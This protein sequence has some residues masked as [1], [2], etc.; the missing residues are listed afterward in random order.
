MSGVMA[1]HARGMVHRDLSPRNLLLRSD[2]RLVVA[3]FGTVRHLD[4]ATMTANENFGSLLYIS[5]QQFEDAHSAQPSDDL[6]SI[7]QIAWHLLIG[8]PPMGA[9][10]AVRG[11]RD[12][13][14]KDL[15]DL[16]E[17]LRSD[18]PR[19]RADAD[20]AITTLTHVLGAPPRV[21]ADDQAIDD[22][23]RLVASSR[24]GGSVDADPR[25]TPD[26][27]LAFEAAGSASLAP[28]VAFELRNGTTLAVSDMGLVDTGA[29][30]SLFPLFMMELLGV[31]NEDCERHMFE[32]AAGAGQIL[33]M[34]TPL[35]MSILD[36]EF[37]IKASF[38]ETPIT[39]LGRND[40]L[41]HFEVTI[42]QRKQVL[43][44]KPVGDG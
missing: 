25:P 15:S 41:A 40:V 31:S 34:D 7:G 39:L 32:A 27:V 9:V 29:D 11:L 19:W 26:Y 33:T 22:G 12:D 21:G 23:V 38:G 24:L 14:P 16:I 4:D 8:R 6:F 13:V 1:L 17:A 44:L 43:R 36:Q 10:R 20:R 42:D 37:P 3:D 18:N 28:I 2:G 5:P 35:M 30:H